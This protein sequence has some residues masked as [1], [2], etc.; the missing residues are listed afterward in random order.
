MTEVTAMKRNKH[1]IFI[2]CFLMVVGLSGSGY[3]AIPDAPSIHIAK[4]DFEEAEIRQIMKTLSEIS[5][6]NI[7]VDKKIV[8]EI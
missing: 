1:I 4:L 6:Q 2:L 3:S 5:G 7:I 8:L